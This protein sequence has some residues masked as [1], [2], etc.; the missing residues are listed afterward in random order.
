MGGICELFSIVQGFVPKFNYSPKGLNS[1]PHA[2]YCTPRLQDRAETPHGTRTYYSNNRHD[3][4]PRTHLWRRHHH[5]RVICARESR[6]ALPTDTR[7]RPVFCMT[8][9]N[10]QIAKVFARLSRKQSNMG[11][12]RTHECWRTLAHAGARAHGGFRQVVWMGWVGGSVR[13]GGGVG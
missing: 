8:L 10:T 11:A 1:L 7:G 9:L 13:A 12:A 2:P 3:G 5:R 6:Y 4:S